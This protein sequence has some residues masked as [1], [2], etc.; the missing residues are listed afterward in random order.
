ADPSPRPWPSRAAA[1][2]SSGLVHRAAWARSGPG[3][4]CG[5]SS[6][7]RWLSVWPWGFSVVG[8][9]R[10]RSLRGWGRREGVHEC[11]HPSC[12]LVRRQV[13]EQRRDADDAA[14]EG[15]RIRAF[16]LEMLD[17]AA[18]NPEVLAAAR[19]LPELDVLAIEPRS[20]RRHL[21]R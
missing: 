14:V 6:W 1:P 12:S 15:S 19:V 3:F 16:H 9:R 8:G 18:S 13:Q 7:P 5:T 10:P 17:L 4:V 21:H 20:E 2:P 11:P